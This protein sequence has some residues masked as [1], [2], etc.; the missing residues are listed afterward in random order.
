MPHD[1]KDLAWCV[2]AVTVLAAALTMGCRSPGGHRHDGHEHSH[3]SARPP[4]SRPAPASPGVSPGT[5]SSN[6]QVR[7]TAPA[8]ALRPQRTCPVSGEE[9]GSMGNP[10]PVTVE[11][12]TIFVCC[13]GCVRKVQQSPDTYLAKVRDETGPGD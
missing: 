2:S 6:P 8:A 9:L 7:S 5:I 13:Q 1:R 10:I 4:A 3:A 12:R 11:G